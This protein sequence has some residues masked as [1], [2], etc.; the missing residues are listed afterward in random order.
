VVVAS[1]VRTIQISA[2]LTVTI[3]PIQIEIRKAA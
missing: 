2:A 3:Q 1:R